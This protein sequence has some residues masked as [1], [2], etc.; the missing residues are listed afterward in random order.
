M[1]QKE[2]L[3]ARERIIKAVLKIIGQKGAVKF[4]VRE[5]SKVANVNLSAVNYYFRSTKNLLN[6]VETY[7]AEKV[8]EISKILIEENLDPKI[9]LI[10]WSKAMMELLAKNTG[11]IWIMANKITQK[12]NPGILIEKLLED[13]NYILGKLISELTGN[14]DE[15][16]I[17]FKIM[18]LISGISFPIIM[19]NGLG[20]N[21]NQNFNDPT[22]IEKYSN[23][24]VNSILL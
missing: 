6:E 4:T 13:N 14:T 3:E 9:R 19:C 8:Q 24:I 20:K 18:Q 22:V 7:F 12:G 5:I 2:K 15:Q 21:L 1:T 17:A 23:M 10:N 16:Y 11:I